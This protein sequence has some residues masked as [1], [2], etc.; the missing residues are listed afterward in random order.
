MVF[1]KTFY[2][3]YRYYSS[4]T[5]SGKGY[6]SAILV[7][8]FFLLM[9]ISQI[10]VFFWGGSMLLGSN[11]IERFL[12]AMGYLI[13][14]YF[15]LTLFFKKRDIPEMEK[16]Y[17]EGDIKHDYLILWG[18]VVL[19]CLAFVFIVLLRKNYEGNMV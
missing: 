3:L 8:A 19:N 14:V 12:C 17:E 9:H 5:I 4:G 15:I 6:H 2:L 1:K 11:K 16:Y 18:Y 13:P 7:L 10:K